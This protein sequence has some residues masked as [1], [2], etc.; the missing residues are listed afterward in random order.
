MIIPFWRSCDEHMNLKKVVDKYF[1]ITFAKQ[2]TIITIL[3]HGF[4]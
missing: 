2:I 4:L 1:F 3:R